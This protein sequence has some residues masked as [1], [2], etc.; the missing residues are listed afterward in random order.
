[1]KLPRKFIGTHADEVLIEEM[2]ASIGVGRPGDQ[3][4]FATRSEFVRRA[5]ERL[6]E[7]LRGEQVSS[8]RPSTALR[9]AR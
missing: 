6:L 3:G 8:A 7:D 5:I 2:D 1:M 9:I 4:Y